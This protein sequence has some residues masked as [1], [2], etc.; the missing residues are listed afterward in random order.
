MNCKN[1]QSEINSDQNY[2][3]NCGAEIVDKRITIKGLSS[4]LLASIGWDN[5]FFLTLRDLIIRPQ[6]VFEKYLNGTR[7]KHTNPFAFFTIGVALSVF[8]INIYADELISISSFESQKPAEAI[9]EQLNEDISESSIEKKNAISEQQQFFNSKAI[10]FQ[11]KY[12]Y[13]LSFIL[14]PFYTLISFLVF[15]KPENF[16]EHLVI[17]AYIQG[18]TLLL[19]L[20][21][22]ILSLVFKYDFHTSA[23]IILTMI[24]YSYA[25]KKYRHYSIGKSLLKL[26]RFFIII[27]IV[28]ILSVLI[29][30]FYA[31]IFLK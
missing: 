12:Y 30:F 5:R 24:Y 27:L 25:Y 29:G 13:Y 14:L 31:M 28:L 3:S 23:A 17:N 9:Y 20:P 19:V 2:C 6:V 7:K 4:T 1:C 15:R 22:F 10:N 18:L 16:G 11:Y 21:F 8:I 26:L